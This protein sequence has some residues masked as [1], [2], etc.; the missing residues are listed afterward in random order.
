M[1]LPGRGD[2][3]N[4]PSSEASH[5]IVDFYSGKKKFDLP[6]IPF[7]NECLSG[8]YKFYGTDQIK[9]K[10][11]NNDDLLAMHVIFL[12]QLHRVESRC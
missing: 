12:F 9:M 5:Y 7:V 10:S 11:M 2:P 8:Y 6:K 4:Q 3:D 1:R